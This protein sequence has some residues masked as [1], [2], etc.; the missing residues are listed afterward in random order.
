M[1]NNEIQNLNIFDVWKKA[2]V[3]KTENDQ[4][5]P[6]YF[7]IFAYPAPSGFFHVGTLRS[8]VYP[9]VIAKFKRFTGYNVYFPAGIHA[10]GLPAVQFSEK[11][12]SGRY[13]NYLKEN[14]CTPDIIEKLKSPQG[15]VDYFRDNYP[16]I[17]KQMGFFINEESGT[18]T[19]IDPGYKKFIQWQFRTLYEK[20]YLVQKEYVSSYCP[21]DGPVSIDTAETDLS[22]GGNAQIIEY[23]VIKFQ[24]NQPFE[25][26]GNN[27]KNIFMMVATLR[28]ETIFGVTNIWI[29][30]NTEYSIIFHNDEFYII[31]SNSVNNIKTIFEDFTIIG[32]INSNDIT[33]K[34]IINPITKDEI[35][36]IPNKIVNDRIGTGIVMSVPYHSPIDFMAYNESINNNFKIKEPII[37]VKS[38]ING[39]PS[40]EAIKKHSIKK[41]TEISRI[42][43]ANSYI[44]NKEVENGRMISEDP[45]FNN[46]SVLIARNKIIEIIIR[47]KNGYKGMFFNKPVIC[48]C[49]ERIQIRFISNQWFIRYSDKQTKRIIKNHITKT[50]NIFPKSIH[51]QMPN[52]IDWYEDRPCVRTGNWL[53]T[54]FPPEIEHDK[55]KHFIIEPI[56]DSTI[57]PSFYIVSKFLHSNIITTKSLNDAFFDFIFLDKGNIDRVSEQTN[58]KQTILKEIQTQF[59]SWYP[60]DCN[61]GGKEHITVHFPVFLQMHAMMFPKSFMPKN[62]FINWWVMQ[63]INTKQKIG[64][65]KRGAGPIAGVMEKYSPDAIRLFYC[66]AASPHA[67]IEWSFKQIENYQ[68]DIN[69]IVNLISVI[70]DSFKNPSDPDPNRIETWLKYKLHEKF[71]QMYEFLENYEIRNMV[72]ECFYS[73]PKIIW[74]FIHR[75]GVF[76]SSIIS[77][78]KTWM[79]F[80]ATITPFMAEKMYSKM[81]STESI[82][83]SN[84]IILKPVSSIT[85]SIIKE[86]EYIDDVINDILTIKRFVKNVNK[87]F[88]YIYTRNKLLDSNRSQKDI[89]IECKSYISKKTGCVPIIDSGFFDDNNKFQKDSNKPILVFR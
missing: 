37:V 35:P 68:R 15:V 57:Y 27:I 19:T 58:I 17:L 30:P 5:K 51:Q 10:S 9:D 14:N 12:R 81:G 47:E 59:K 4:T 61:F 62:I 42:E 87:K 63:N 36:I 26:N 70:A 8:Y 39:I 77:D 72:Q 43:S 13:N 67:D 83:T 44:I 21:N 32:T 20:D 3:Y 75:D 73:V 11:V 28:P 66:H 49:G 18:P 74:H 7:I 46:T 22:S 45:E 84:N 71:N 48:R 76:S 82:F 33:N 80:L 69:K 60:V 29:S 89:L 25:F 65:S 53:G 40:E 41:V 86:E 16:K 64:K 56:A 38:D 1:E 85:S 34:A 24:V 54:N 79:M 6:K 2:N 50:M 55:E 52:I 31:S 23:A 78:I 88:V